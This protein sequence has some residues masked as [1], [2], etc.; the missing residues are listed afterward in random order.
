MWE[1][2]VNLINLFLESVSWR[3]MT[4]DTIT[5]WTALY[6]ALGGPETCT[7]DLDAVNQA[8]YV[9]RAVLDMVSAGLDVQDTPGPDPC[10]VWQ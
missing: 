3:I 6:V 4:P 10:K 9:V 5:M 7:P 8:Q 2:I 1:L